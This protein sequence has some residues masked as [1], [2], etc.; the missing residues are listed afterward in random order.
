MKFHQW[1][2][3]TPPAACERLFRPRLARQLAL[4][5]AF[6]GELLSWFSQQYMSSQGERRAQLRKLPV[7][8]ADAQ[9]Q[10]AEKAPV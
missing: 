8:R 4:Q 9:G 7:L 2:S 1:T 6:L 10:V 5:G 3:F